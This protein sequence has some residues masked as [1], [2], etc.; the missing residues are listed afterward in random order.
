MTTLSNFKETAQKIYAKYDAYL[1]PLGKFLL[2]LVSFSFINGKLGYMASLNSVLIVLILALLCSFLT[3]NAIVIVGTCLIFGHLYSH[4]LAALIAVGGVVIVLF[5]IYFSFSAKE[6]YALIFTMLALVLKVPCVVPIVLGLIATPFS[7]VP[8][9]LGTIAYYAVESVSGGTGQAVGAAGEK[10]LAILDD[11]Q[12]LLKGI[13]G[14]TE[15]VLMVVLLAAV[16]I[17]VYM[18]RRMAIKYAWRAAILAGALT[19]FVI[20]FAGSLILGISGGV[21]WAILGTIIAV[22]V[23][24]LVQLL[25]FNADYKKTTSVQF[26]D[27]EYYYYVRAV[28]KVKKGREDGG[29][30]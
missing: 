27:E 4:S 21:I 25:L 9:C 15:M 22:V 14:E 16:L 17:T 11:I 12:A 13:A 26:E 19:Y 6:S 30:Y 20:Y 1:I 2:A 10:S 29:E 3:A 23:G 5:L 18:V 8:I 7:I 24:F 28:P